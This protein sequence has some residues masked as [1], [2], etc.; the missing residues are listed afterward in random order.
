MAVVS[1][2]RGAIAQHERSAARMAR[3]QQARL[4]A[5]RLRLPRRVKGAPVGAG[6]SG[7]FGEPVAGGLRGPAV[8]GQAGAALVCHAAL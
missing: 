5:S 2:R 4:K 7:S 6:Q 1:W 8:P 3:W